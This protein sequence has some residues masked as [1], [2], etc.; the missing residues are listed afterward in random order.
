MRLRLELPPP[1]ILAYIAGLMAFFIGTE[2]ILF[3]LNNQTTFSWIDVVFWAVLAFVATRTRVQLPL[4]ASMNHLFVVALAISTVMPVWLAPLLVF[5]CNTDMKFGNP[6]YP[7]YKDLFNRTQGALATAF[8]GLVWYFVT[9]HTG[10]FESVILR[11]VGEGIG[12]AL[13]SLAYFGMNLGAMIAVIHLSTGV[14][15]RKITQVAT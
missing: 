8:S 11:H 14:S 13:A 15:I 4:A 12:I 6:S 2:W 3:R 5:L 7:W 10:N 9:S 1:K